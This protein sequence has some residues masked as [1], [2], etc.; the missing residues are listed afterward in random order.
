MT[1][2]SE[3][4]TPPEEQP[5]PVDVYYATP[6]VDEEMWRYRTT[7]EPPG[8]LDAVIDLLSAPPQAAI[9]E[10]LR[11]SVSKSLIE[12]YEIDRGTA[13]VSL[14]AEQLEFMPD[15]QDRRAIDQIVLTLTSYAPPGEGGI[16]QISFK[17][18][19]VAIS[20]IKPGQGSSRPGEG[21]AFEDFQVLI[22]APTPTIPPTVTTTAPATT[23]DS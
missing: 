10:G 18:D 6:G 19:G 14:N 12:S 8:S 15:Y 1:P 17:V 7:L 2:T 20:I 23:A 21:V 3:T 16:G 13:H 22:A 5:I 4:T 11:T 9:N